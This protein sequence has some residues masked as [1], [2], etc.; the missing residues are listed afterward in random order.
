MKVGYD[1]FPAVTHAPGLG[2]YSRELVRALVA[3]EPEDTDLQLLDLGRGERSIDG[4]AL[5]LRADAKWVHRRRKHFPRRFVNWMD[6]FLG[7]GA[8]GWVGG[9]DLFHHTAPEPL[10]VEHAIEILP[11][12]DLPEEDSEAHVELKQRL[13]RIEH[14]I[15][16]SEHYRGEV[17]R[18]FEWPGDRI[19]VTPVGCD[20]WVREFDEL[21]HP[22]QPPTIVVLGAM[23]ESRFPHMIRKA[24]ELL[25]VDRPDSKL[26]FCGRPGDAAE[27][28][29]RDRRFSGA[30]NSI[31]WID[32]P[33]EADLPGLVGRA[34]TMV[35][36]SRDEGTPVTVL[37]GLRAGVPVVC[38]PLPA[39]QE[40]LGETALYFEGKKRDA[41]KLTEAL[42]QSIESAFDPKARAERIA[43]A[44][45]FSWENCA[46]Q[47]LA[48]WRKIAE[49]GPGRR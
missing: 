7:F 35:H 6:R 21:P 23:R 8:D 33:K 43:L 5:G 3:L 47:T 19:H 28:F 26:V 41:H 9:C 29:M 17:M 1:Y 44:T 27:Q 30:R 38:S 39:L 36:L 31:E 20:H 24:F 49:F 4:E 25:L 10:L 42:S 11:L 15:V 16:F 40:V 13:E 34:S 32:Q 22:T 45:P 2:R 46:R 12:P 14:V 37:E 18:R 48:V